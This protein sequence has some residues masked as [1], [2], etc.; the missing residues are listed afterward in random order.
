MK[1]K[2]IFEKFIQKSSN[3][4]ETWEIVKLFEEERERFKQE[5]SSYENEIVKSKNELK[6]IRGEIKELKTDILNLEELKSQKQ[7][8]IHF[9]NQKLFSSKIKHNIVKIKDEK[10]RIVTEKK[11]I[12][13]KPAETIDIYLKDGS[14]AKARPVKRLF[15]DILYKKYRIILKENKSLKDQIL[16]LELEKTKLEI[17]LRDINTEDILKQKNLKD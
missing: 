13:P 1:D 17:E 12:L 8:E 9:I 4:K 14:I 15:T 2:A 16:N 7:D 5:C 10:N 6:K 11:D 3:I